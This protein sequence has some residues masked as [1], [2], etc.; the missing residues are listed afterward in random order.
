MQNTQTAQSEVLFQKLGQT[1]Y[2]FSEINNELVYSALP[3]GMDPR[4]T[5]L[6]LFH[7]IEDHMKKVSKQM[8]DIKIQAA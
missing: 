7:V 1:W 4:S 5:K 3:E 6:E 2:V 8:K